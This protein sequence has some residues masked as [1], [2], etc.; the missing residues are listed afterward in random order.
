LTLV[1]Y[2]LFLPRSTADLKNFDKNGIKGYEFKAVIDNVTTDICRK[3]NGRKY[4]VKPALEYQEKVNRDVKK[5]IDG[6]GEDWQIYN[7]AM[8]YL[9]KNDALAN[10]NKDGKWESE[11]I[12][13]T[14]NPEKQGKRITSIYKRAEDV[15]GNKLPRPP[16]EYNCR[17]RIK[18]II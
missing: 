16:M 18:P 3:F 1:A 13:R 17:S 11:I 2:L 9:H 12:L 15:P 4:L 8:K 6:G 5:I 14:K 7:K 10:E